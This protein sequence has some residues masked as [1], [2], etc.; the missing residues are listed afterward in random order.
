MKTILALFAGIALNAVA[1]NNFY[2]VLVGNDAR[3]TNATIVDFIPAHVVI[4]HAGGITDTCI[5]NLPRATANEIVATFFRPKNQPPQVRQTV[6]I[7][8]VIDTWNRCQL[9]GIG[10]VILYDL[11]QSVPD[12]FAKCNQLKA[13]IGAE[14]ERVE[15]MRKNVARAEANLPSAL[16]PF[17]YFQAGEETRVKNMRVD[18]ENASNNL[19]KMKA[20]LDKMESDL[21]KNTTVIA[22]PT[23]AKYSEVPIWQFVEI[24][25]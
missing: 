9:E 7:I 10:E 4:R 20:R 1:Q 25:P 11:P 24:A 22:Y 13:G 6:H 8:S 2:S 5:T 17:D 12:Y 21:I 15:M 18:Y 19:D 14:E 3:Y 23:G 16:N